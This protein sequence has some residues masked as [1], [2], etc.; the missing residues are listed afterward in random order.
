M[1]EMNGQSKPPKPKRW[2]RRLI[3][4]LVIIV[5]L[6]IILVFA[7]APFL[8]SVL[9][10]SQGTRRGDR[11]LSSTPADY[12]APYE[13]VEFTTSDGVIIRGWLIRPTTKPATI[14]YAHGLFRSRRELLERAIETWKSGYGALLID[15][16]NHGSSGEARTSLGYNERLDV[17]AAVRF[18]RDGAS[19]SDQVVLYGLSM[20]AT[21]C[22]HAAAETPEVDA[23]IS[24]SAFLSFDQTI[25]H[26]VRL[27]FRLPP[28]PIAPQAKFYIQ[29]RADFDGSR[30]DSLVAVRQIG[31]RPIMFIAGA[32][33]RRIPP[34][35]ATQLH[36]A[37][38][39]PDSELLVV[40]G[41]GSQIHGHAY[42]AD[43]ALYTSKVLAFLAKL[44][45]DDPASRN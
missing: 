19:T 11:Q 36:A 45:P 7:V 10:T 8:M 40:D 25:D 4:I 31:N 39:N 29:Q 21:A 34:E 2:R 42:Q 38:A 9:V 24:D 41:P 16:R 27:L 17:E 14:V 26:H 12:H 37:A 6:V 13:D 43:T 44:E 5:A 20:G 22:L 23:V 28:F 1:D 15:Q 18:L 3:R 33:D 32:N 35:I 30:L